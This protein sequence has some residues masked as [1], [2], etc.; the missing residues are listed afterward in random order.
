MN[1]NLFRK[2]L[3]YIIIVL[4][5]VVSIIPCFCVV[6]EEVKTS[7][8]DIIP[9]DAKSVTCYVFDKK[10]NGESSVVLSSV[11]FD[12]FFSVFEDLNYMVAFHPFSDDTRVLKLEFVD[13]LDGLGLVPEGFSRDD[14]VRLLNPVVGGRRALF[15]GGVLSGG[16]GSSF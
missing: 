5:F 1:N 16:R 7:D 12:R 13:L 2:T 6:S 11:D 14:V 9:L 10:G 4:F 8:I 3:V 15:P